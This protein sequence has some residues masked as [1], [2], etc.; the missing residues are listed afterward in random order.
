M[1]RRLLIAA[2]L[3][4]MSLAAAP[5]ADAARK[6]P[7]GFFGTVFDGPIKSAAPTLIDGEF[8][9][10]SSAGVESARTNFAWGDIQPVRGTTTFVKTDVLVGAAAEHGQIL[11]PVVTSAPPWARK[12]PGKTGSPPKRVSDY[13]ALL[14]A[15]VSRYGPKGSF[16]TENATV[17]KRPIRQWQIWNEPNL[18][19][20]WARPKGQGFKKIAPAYGKLL[21]A[22]RKTLKKADRGSKVVLAALTNFSW[23]DLATLY[24]RGHIKGAFDVAAINAYSNRPSDYLKIAGAVRKVLRRNG[25]RKVPI[26]FT[27]FTAP[28][29]KGRIRI[30]S[31]QRRFVTTD[32][33]MAKV[34]KA[35]YKAFATKGRRSLGIERA[36]WYT[37]ASTYQKGHPLGFFEFAGLRRFTGAAPSDRP[38]VS[39]YRQ[40]ARKYA[41]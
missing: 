13:T 20:Q 26:W 14:R 32:A 17:P 37:W 34:V 28:A 10:M 16:W 23:E 7:R 18:P 15:L 24:S 39:A 36:Y 22:S 25:A 41:G 21:K 1:P 33:Q 2:C 29:A 40:I 12:Y 4:A 5:T 31:Y 27:E 8:G 19:Y 30:P 9:R 3:L 35:A 38:A 6:V 11:L